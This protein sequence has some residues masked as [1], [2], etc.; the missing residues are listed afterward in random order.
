MTPCWT[1]FQ[2]IQMECKIP[3]R[4]CNDP[5]LVPTTTITY[6]QGAN[7]IPAGMTTT[8][9][10]T[11]PM[12]F[13]ATAHVLTLMSLIPTAAT[14]ISSPVTN[15]IQPTG[16][17]SQGGMTTGG[18]VIIQHLVPSCIAGTQLFSEPKRATIHASGQYA[19]M[20]H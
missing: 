5:L 18:N 13:T 8:A 6:G 1:T 17:S 14:R 9:S 7:T 15:V 2:L 19:T 16:I 3:R 12:H 11:T 4:Q 20:Y 10:I